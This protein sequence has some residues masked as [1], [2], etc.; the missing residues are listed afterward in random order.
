MKNRTKCV[1]A[2]I[3]LLFSPALFAANF[4]V[5]VTGNDSNPGS[6]LAPFATLER[7]RDAVRQL[8]TAGPLRPGDI[9]IEL[10]GGVYPLAQ[11]LQFTDKDSGT[12]ASPI[13]YQARTGEVVRVTGGR[14]VAG[15][16]RV[17]DP[18][19]QARLDAAARDQV[20]QADLKALGITDLQGIGDAR[21]YQ[22]DPG[23]ELFFQDQP[24]TLA[25]YPNSGY[26]H[27]IDVLDSQGVV[28]SGRAS[29]AEGRFVCDDDRI[30]RWVQEK[31]IWL[32]GFWVWDWADQRIPL[33][34]LDPASRTL[35]LAGQPGRNYDLRKGQWFYAENALSEL[36]CPGEWYIDRESGFLYFWPPAP[37]R[38]GDVVVSVARDLFQLNDVSH[39]RFR[40][41]LVEA[42]RS[43]AFIVRGRTERA[44]R[45]QHHS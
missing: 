45:G 8:K 31:G 13:V 35:S 37:L 4:V 7:A 1:T 43:S 36:D 3:V 24:M 34:R 20:Y 12:E 15:W 25:R 18:S 38:D 11:P 21:V 32:H 39:V 44:H 42:G 16:A 23:L 30:A 40:N 27:I 17:S 41:L 26:M 5:S 14:R 29:T 9:T 2:L 10:R 28:S 19:V 6:D 22:S 33:G